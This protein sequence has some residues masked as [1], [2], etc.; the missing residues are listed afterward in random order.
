MNDITE[1]K[2]VE[3]IPIATKKEELIGS[4][5]ARVKHYSNNFKKLYE[6]EQLIKL[7]K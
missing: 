3:K 1:N 7:F 5:Q 2:F 4:F 6:Y